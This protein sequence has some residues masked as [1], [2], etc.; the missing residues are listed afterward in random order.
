MVACRWRFSAALM[1]YSCD[2]VIVPH[3]LSV[4]LC[5]SI[6]VFRWF[7]PSP[8]V[9]TLKPLRPPIGG[10]VE[11]AK[12][13][14]ICTQLKEFIVSN[15]TATYPSC[16]PTVFVQR[17]LTSLLIN[18]SCSSICASIWRTL[19]CRNLY[20]PCANVNSHTKILCAIVSRSPHNMQLSSSI[21]TT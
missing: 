18:M 20:L 2:C 9:S 12:P 17:I 11:V 16:L 19:S 14:L 10:S 3:R 6:D 13:L 5:Q 15:V 4:S 7:Q 1:S 8:D 21:T